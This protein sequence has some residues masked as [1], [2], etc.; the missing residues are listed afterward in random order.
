MATHPSADTTRRL[1]DA[2]YTLCVVTGTRQLDAAL[3]VARQQMVAVLRDRQPPAVEEAASP[4]ARR[5]A[6]PLPPGYRRRAPS[7]CCLRVWSPG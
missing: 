5:W 7:A 2:A 3:F 6:P 4:R 1:D